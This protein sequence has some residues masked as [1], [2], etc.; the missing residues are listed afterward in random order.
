MLCKTK[1]TFVIIALLI[2][3][4]LS[5][6][7][8]KVSEEAIIF[9]NFRAG[10]FTIF[11]D[12]GK[13][14]GFL[15]DSIGIVITNQHVVSSAKFVRV[16]VNDS[17]KVKGRVIASDKVR[18]VAAILI[19]PSVIKGL[20][21]LRIAPKRDELA[22][23]GEKVIAIGS[24][25]NQEKIVT[26][27]II[28]KI[29]KGAIITDVNINHGNSGGPLMN[30]D[31]EVIAINT[32]GDF[33]NEGG[34][35]VSGSIP[36][37][38]FYGFIDTVWIQSRNLTPPD[39]ILLP[40]VPKESFP[41]WALETAAAK[42]KWDYNPYIVS[43]HGRVEK[44][45]VIFGTPPMIYRSMKEEELKISKKRKQRE[46]EGNI[47]DSDSF[48]PY[49]DLKDWYQYLG[50]YAPLVYLKIIPK[51]G[52]TGTSSA[53]NILGAIAAGAVGSNYYYGSH[54]Y[55][56]KGDLMGACLKEDGDTIQEI[57]RNLVFIPLDFNTADYY[58]SYKGSDLAKAGLF[59]Y[60]LENF[61]PK[62]TIWPNI[63]LELT[64]LDKPDEIQ[65]VE[66]PRET[67]EQ[68]WLDF[69]PYRE[70]IEAD[71]INMVIQ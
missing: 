43:N 66:I 24:P 45:N 4:N 51:I 63:T 10:V 5:N 23:E 35:G 25:L 18:D 41:L 22:I 20:P 59:I 52:E 64:S 67:L 48:D 32:F 49:S 27:G 54:K 65:E 3:Y 68:I 58:G 57:N 44:F 13:G 30:M 17:V 11:C 69:E 16:Q 9:K 36:I 12:D 50:E 46:K 42:K 19:N 7:Q 39:A 61:A 33:T 28:S 14:S 8:R 53:L 55:E 37:S 56:F 70:Q 60:S 2:L 21:V 40:V 71:S 29:E 1:T 31:G 62:N 38:L 47:T 26:S 34:P 6:G 15:I